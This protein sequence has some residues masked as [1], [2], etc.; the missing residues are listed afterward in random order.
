[1]FTEVPFIHDWTFKSEYCCH[2]V[3]YNADIFCGSAIDVD[4][5][6][7]VIKLYM[8]FLCKVIEI[9]RCAHI[10]NDMSTFIFIGVCQ[11]VSGRVV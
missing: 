6:E 10:I 3:R 11:I 9:Y 2:V 7:K 5:K 1:M 8:R 4:R